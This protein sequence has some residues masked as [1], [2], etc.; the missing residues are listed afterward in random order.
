MG[1]K[2]NRKR[3]DILF[4]LAGGL[5]CLYGCFHTPQIWK[6]E[7]HLARAK[8]HLDKSNFETA[9]KECRAALQLYPQ[10]LGDQANFMIA[11]IYAHPENPQRDTRKAIEAFETVVRRYPESQFKIQAEI[12]EKILRKNQEAAASLQAHNREIRDLKDAL[13]TLEQ[14]IEKLRAEHATEIAQKNKQI[15]ELK[16]NIDQLKEIDLKIEEKKRKPA[17]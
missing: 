9:L 16:S 2:R 1:Q 8:H 6:T 7:E 4:Y 12:W 5:I 11:L 13:K 17:S 10:S 15:D 3:I 14:R